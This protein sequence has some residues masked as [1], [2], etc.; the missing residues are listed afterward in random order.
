MPLLETFHMKADATLLADSKPRFPQDHQLLL[1]VKHCHFFHL[2]K[3]KVR[4]TTSWHGCRR[5]VW[6]LMHPFYIAP[7]EFI[8]YAVSTNVTIK[9]EIEVGQCRHVFWCF[10]WH[11]EISVFL[12]KKVSWIDPLSEKSLFVREGCNLSPLRTFFCDNSGESTRKEKPARLAR[13]H[14]LLWGLRNR[15]FAQ[16]LSG[17]EAGH[18]VTVGQSPAHMNRTKST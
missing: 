7:Y 6:E 15:P 10:F 3:L 2:K 4:S 13:E 14:L 11:V 17:L 9:L 18:P 5:T 8:G 12:G 1:F 16:L